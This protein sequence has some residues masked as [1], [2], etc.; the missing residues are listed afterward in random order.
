MRSFAILL[1]CDHFVSSFLKAVCVICVEVNVLN[2]NLSGRACGRRKKIVVVPSVGIGGVLEGRK[3][4][5][6]GVVIIGCCLALFTLPQLGGL[7]S[8]VLG[9]PLCGPYTQHW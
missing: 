2:Q 1:P 9:L 8:S 6:F 4:A 5:V 7:R 3:S